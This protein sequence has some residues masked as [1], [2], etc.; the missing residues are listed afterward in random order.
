MMMSWTSLSVFLTI[1]LNNIMNVVCM[2]RPRFIF[3]YKI[4]NIGS[5]TKRGKGLSIAR[6]ISCFAAIGIHALLQCLS[7]LKEHFYIITRGDGGIFV[8]PE[9]KII[10]G[11][12][13]AKGIPTLKQE[14][15]C[16]KAS[17]DYLLNMSNKPPMPPSPEELPPPP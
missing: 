2:R 9:R 1:S 8:L 6:H 10:I 4:Q 17:I 16:Y 11:G 15:P 3:D 13:I 5:G 12:G 14:C 7:R